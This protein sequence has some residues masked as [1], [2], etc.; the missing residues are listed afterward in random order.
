MQQSGESKYRQAIPERRQS[1]RI[2]TGVRW[3]RGLILVMFTVGLALPT[4]D[5]LASPLG[6]NNVWT[7]TS[8]PEGTTVSGEVTIQGTA[9]HANFD[10]YGVLYASGPRPTAESHWVPI[11]FGV[12][13]LVVNGT[14]ATWDTTELPNGQYTLALAVYEQGNTEPNLH[15]TNNITVLNEE[16]TPTPSPTPEEA[17]TEEPDAAEETTPE[18][19]APPAAPTIVQPP[20]ATPRPTATLSPAVAE[21]EG[22]EDESGGLLPEGIL[23]FDAVKESFRVGVQL[24]FLIYAIG[25]LYVLAKAVIR[26]YLRQSHKQTTTPTHED[27]GL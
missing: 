25:I 3:I 14:L 4:A 19:G 26:Y 23:S 22:G 17:A 2:H 16:T 27:P 24:A 15:F 21:G 5:S 1:D 10:S 9:S 7:I 20:T 13:N 6:Q 12:N 18:V 8:P 11:V